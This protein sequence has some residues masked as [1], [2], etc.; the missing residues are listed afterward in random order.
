[1]IEQ[2][3]GVLME[4]RAIDADRAFE[5]LLGH[6]Q[7]TGRKVADVAAAVVES[8]VLLPAT[9]LSEAAPDR[10]RFDPSRSG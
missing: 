3:K 1:M 7:H 10:P 5:L 4:R 8:H 2:A 6:S 9:D